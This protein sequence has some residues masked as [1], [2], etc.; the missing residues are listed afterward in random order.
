MSNQA[1][2][3][4]DEILSNTRSFYNRL[5]DVPGCPPDEMLF[6]YVYGD[7][8]EKELKAV[9]KHIRNCE[10]CMMESLK[11]EADQAEWEYMLNEEPDKALADIISLSDWKHS[12]KKDK[13]IETD[14]HILTKL[15]EWF[16]NLFEGNEWQPGENFLAADCRGAS[17]SED[18]QWSVKRAKRIELGDDAL[19]LLVRLTPLK[20][21]DVEVALQVYPSGGAFYLPH[22]LQVRVVDPAG[23]VLMNAESDMKDDGMEM[24]WIRESGDKFGITVTLGDV[25]IKENLS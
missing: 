4:F 21:E 24:V 9:S 11:M 19:L 12:D 14:T 5:K 22:G 23:E 7:L 6:D 18:T 3:N 2:F 20:E 1:I 17:A 15:K 10:Y 16:K 13:T 25:T 8:T